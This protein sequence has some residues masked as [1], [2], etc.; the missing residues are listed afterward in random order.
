MNVEVGVSAFTDNWAYLKAE[1]A[2]LDRVLMRAIAK[3]RI[4]GQEIDRVA[5]S[6]TDKATSHWWKGFINLDPT[7]GGRQVKQDLSLQMPHALGRYG[8]RLAKSFDQGIPL[9][10]PTLCKHLDLSKF[11]RDLLVLC[12][13][14]EISRRYEKL[15]A[16]LNND[17]ENCSQPTVDLALRL[18]CHS[19]AEW[20]VA[21]NT[22]MPKA[23]LIKHKLLEIYQGK[24]SARSLLA[25]NLCLPDKVATYLLGEDQAIETILPKRRPRRTSKAAS[26]PVERELLVTGNGMLSG[27]DRAE[28]PI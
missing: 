27:S 19:D 28:N 9:G 8:D 26:P 5:R 1:L 7:L 13:A 4:T 12:L 11:E 15:Y 18:F 6:A 22:L 21:R 20:R 3:Q 24:G 14:P 2:W 17:E 25:R 16:V 10:I 23:P